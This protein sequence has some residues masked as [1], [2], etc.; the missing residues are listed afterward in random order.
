MPELLGKPVYVGLF[1]DA[2]HGGNIITRRLHSGILLFVNNYL[3]NSFIKHQNTVKSSTFF[4]ELV[5]LRIAREMIVDIR[6]KLKMFG[7]PLDGPYNIF[8]D[9]NGVV[10]NTRITESNLPNEK[11]QSTT[12]VCVRQPQLGLCVSGRNTRQQTLPNH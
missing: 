2:D 6:I 9:N 12:T 3:I 11:I 8:Y 5:A 1:V 10:N 4:P 7:V